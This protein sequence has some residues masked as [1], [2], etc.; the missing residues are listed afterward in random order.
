MLPYFI[1]YLPNKF[2]GLLTNK[3]YLKVAFWTLERLFLKS[4]A[5]KKYHHI[6]PL[7]FG[8]VFNCRIGPFEKVWHPN[9]PLGEWP[10]CSVSY[11]YKSTKLFTKKKHIFTSVTILLIL[12]RPCALVAWRFSV[13]LSLGLRSLFWSQ[14]E[15]LSNY[16][17][18][19]VGIPE[20][21]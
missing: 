18:G 2:T 4:F 10:W 1:V 20:T 17:L 5:V 6:I 7:V 9:K 13:S 12:T 8:T 11:Y 16:L 3:A 19:S 14:P 21:K 15:R